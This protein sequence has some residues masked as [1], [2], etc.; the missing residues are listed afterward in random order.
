MSGDQPGVHLRSG[1]GLQEVTF[2][3]AVQQHHVRQAVAEYD[4]L[5]QDEF[6]DR[7]GFGRARAYLL[8]I[9]G[10]TYASKAVLGIAFGYA[11]GRPLGPKDFIGGVHGAAGMLRA[12]GFE[13][14]NILNQRPKGRRSH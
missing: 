7:H 5:G 13:G 3:D 1:S 6:L 2:R 10:K 11:M 12:L 4:R 14:R 9:D 8:V